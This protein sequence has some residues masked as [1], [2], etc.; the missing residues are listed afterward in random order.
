MLKRRRGRGTS[1]AAKVAAVRYETLSR[2]LED[3]QTFKGVEP[4]DVPE[5][6]LQTI[7]GDRIYLCAQGAMLIE[8]RGES[9]QPTGGQ[10]PRTIDQGEFVVT[11]TRAVFTGTKQVRQW[12]WSQLDGIEHAE[13]GPFT[14]IAVTNR[15]K[16]FGIRYNKE[17]QDEIRF[18]IELAVATAQG[19][20]DF[21]IHT[22]KDEILATRTQ[23]LT[24][25]D[26]PAHF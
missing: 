23:L 6:H 9:G 1:A 25:E 26:A 15:Q 4:A 17:H 12:L 19:T 22:L 5:M 16:R 20:R 10:L 13:A 14:W 8:P 7:A 3:A 11:S 21:L 2:F 18:I 24:P